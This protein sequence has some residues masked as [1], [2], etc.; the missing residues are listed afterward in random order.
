MDDTMRERIFLSYARNDLDI[1]NRVYT[2]L[3]K[4]KL[5]V[6]FDK[7]DLK[8]GRWKTQIMKAIGRSRFFV[9]CISNAALRKTGDKRPGFQDD[10]LTRA[11]EIAID[12]PEK[13]FTIVPV[14]LEDCGH[15]CY[16]FSL[17]T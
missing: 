17:F 11:Y 6:W 2:G 9:I 13:Q 7:E 5:D 15:R 10:E 1:V 14:R 3:K 16:V 8:P 4:R 12:Q